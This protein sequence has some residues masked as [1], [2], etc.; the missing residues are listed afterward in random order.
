MTTTT[1]EDAYAKAMLADARAMRKL[2]IQREAPVYHAPAVKVTRGIADD[3]LIAD[4][5]TMTTAQ[6]ARKRGVTPEHIGRR[7][8]R[9][10]ICAVSQW[11]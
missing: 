8:R 2:P 4:A 6:I 1:F 11:G 5:K 3:D 9:I 10:G 7:L